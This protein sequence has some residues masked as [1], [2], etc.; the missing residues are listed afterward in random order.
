MLRNSILIILFILHVGFLLGCSDD[1]TSTSSVEFPSIGNPIDRIPIG[2]VEQNGFWVNVKNDNHRT[3]MSSNLGFKTPCYISKEA[4]SNTLMTCYLDMLEGDLYLYDIDIQYNSPPRLCASVTT[5]PAWHY[6]QSVGVG[7]RSVEIRVF[8][9]DE[10]PA[11]VTDCQAWEES[12]ESMIAC[13]AHP[14]LFG[15]LSTFGPSCVYNRE[16]SANGVNCCL[17]DYTFTRHIVAT[18]APGAPILSTE[19]E[20]RQWN[21]G[22]ATQCLGGAVRGGWDLVDANGYPARKVERVG[23]A[24]SQDNLGLNEAIQ[25]TRP[26]LVTANSFS[27]YSNFFSLEDT[28]HRHRGFH[29]DRFSNL[30]Y[31]VDPIDDLDGSSIRPGRPFYQFRCLD[32]GFEVLHQIDL[33]IREWNTLEDYLAFELT[34]GAT[35]N[36]NRRGAEGVDCDYSPIF[37]SG[38]CNDFRDFDDILFDVGGAYLTDILPVPERDAIRSTYFPNIVY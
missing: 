37:G 4:T 21:S 5:Q 34:Q 25:L 20:L 17:G 6:N 14:E 2:Q 18:T 10:G 15:A 30:P 31:A 3:I 8:E 19:V 22:G 1:D 35:Y 12:S 9:P 11:V 24:D 38:Q 29:D 23:R 28:P 27:I 33:F 16:G 13:S 7:P 26:I 32:D 36:P